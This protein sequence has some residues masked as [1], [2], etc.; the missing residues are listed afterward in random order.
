MNPFPMLLKLFEA[1]VDN[2]KQVAWNKRASR[3]TV[4]VKRKALLSL[5]IT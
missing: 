4:A 1:V 2:A 5:K 3:I